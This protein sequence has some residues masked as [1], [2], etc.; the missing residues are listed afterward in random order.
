MLYFNFCNDGN[1]Y[2]LYSLFVY[3]I[4][5]EQLLIFHFDTFF[6]LIN[7]NVFRFLIAEIENIIQF[8]R[9]ILDNIYIT[10]I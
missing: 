2:P 8:N 1:S 9:R 3:P 7:C 5:N 6:T 4:I 10:S